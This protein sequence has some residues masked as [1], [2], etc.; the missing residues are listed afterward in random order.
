MN[1]EVL[2]KMNLAAAEANLA[3]SR[4][5][6]AEKRVAIAKDV[7]KWL[8]T[9]ALVAKPGKYLSVT[10]SD[11]SGLK[12]CKACALGAVFACAIDRS[13]SVKTTA[14]EWFN[15]GEVQ[16]DEHY[17]GNAHGMRTALKPYFTEEQL[18]TIEN[19]FEKQV[20]SP[21]EGDRFDQY[22]GYH[23]AEN[24]TT[25]KAVKYNR[26][27]RSGKERLTRIMRNIIR[28]GGEFRP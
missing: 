8:N 6:A 3:F 26:G 16:G 23:H 12:E 17:Y 10:K 13:P 9:G 15:P 28:N 7:I 22:T 11:N 18:I 2:A 19:A 14:A 1:Q 25:I 4:M 24:S 21:L 5:S 20:I 27:I